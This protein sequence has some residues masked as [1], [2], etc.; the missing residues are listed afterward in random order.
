MLHSYIHVQPR[1]LARFML[2]IDGTT[3]FLVETVNSIDSVYRLI[4]II[5]VFNLVAEVTEAASYLKS[6]TRALYNIV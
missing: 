4:Q 2:Q 1:Q 5:K 3:T 6:G